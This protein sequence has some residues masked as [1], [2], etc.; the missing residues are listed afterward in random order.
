MK[1]LNMNLVVFGAALAAAVYLI[2]FFVIN[3]GAGPEAAPEIKT[4][5]IVWSLC[6]LLPPFIVA[7]KA[8][9]VGALYGLVIGLV[10]L[11]LIVL[12]GNILPIFMLI[13]IYM[14]APL[15][16]YLGEITARILFKP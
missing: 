8:S 12:T 5:F 2:A 11:I 14:F 4:I 16:G 13:I 3:V 6:F 7:I 15:G 10:P 1:Y 9:K